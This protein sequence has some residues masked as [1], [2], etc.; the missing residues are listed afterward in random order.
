MYSTMI[1]YR[2]HRVASNRPQFEE[3]TTELADFHDLFLNYRHR[4][5]VGMVDDGDLKS[6]GCIPV[7]VQVPL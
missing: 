5:D 3:D 7:R 2:D 6:L 1:A 4:L